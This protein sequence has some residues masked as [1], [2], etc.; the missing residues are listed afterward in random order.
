MAIEIVFK[1]TFQNVEAALH[2]SLE[3]CGFRVRPSPM[4]EGVEVKAKMGFWL[5]EKGNKLL[6]L[7]LPFLFKTDS[8]AA[9]IAAYQDGTIALTV[10][11]NSS[12]GGNLA[13]GATNVATSAVGSLGPIGAAA[14]FV[15]ATAGRAVASKA[16]EAAKADA[17]AKRLASIEDKLRQRLAGKIAYEGPVRPDVQQVPA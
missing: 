13:G 10:R 11:E 9:I 1:E 3:D 12:F 4:A 17:L 2:A 16:D 14:G 7:V 8:V 5:G 6:S 15:G